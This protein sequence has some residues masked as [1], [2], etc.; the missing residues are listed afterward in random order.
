MSV[1]DLA[2]PAWTEQALCAQT[3]PD[4]FFPEKGGSTRQAVAICRRCPVREQCLD[5]A[6][7]HGERFGIWGGVSERDRRAMWGELVIDEDDLGET[8]FA[9]GDD[10]TYDIDL[11][12]PA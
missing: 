8:E 12:E 6:L 11:G 10:F 4:E 1:F 5:Y 7:E 2:A 9:D 3:D